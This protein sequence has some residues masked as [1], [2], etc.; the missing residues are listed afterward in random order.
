MRMKGS[1]IKQHAL[2]VNQYGFTEAIYL[3]NEL[4]DFLW[5]DPQDCVIKLSEAKMKWCFYNRQPK[6]WHLQ[7]EESPNAPHPEDMSFEAL[8]EH[9]KLWEDHSNKQE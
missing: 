2:H 9:F 7:F 3:Y 5:E 6:T 4:G 1:I 8:K